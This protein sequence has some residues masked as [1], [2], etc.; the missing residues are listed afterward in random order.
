MIM[1]KKENAVCIFSSAHTRT[2][3]SLSLPVEIIKSAEIA[4]FAAYTS[5]TKSTA[6]ASRFSAPNRLSTEIFEGH[7]ALGTH[8]E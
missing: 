2:I 5:T 4:L 7:G 6:N 3:A 8:A 1:Q